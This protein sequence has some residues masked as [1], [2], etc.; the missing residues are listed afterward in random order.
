VVKGCYKGVTKVLQ[1]C[2]PLVGG[3]LGDVLG[4]NWLFGVCLLD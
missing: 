3:G 1:G 2:Y 4:D